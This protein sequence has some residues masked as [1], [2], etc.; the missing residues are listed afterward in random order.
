[1]K[2]S[3]NQMADNNYLVD[4][5]FKMTTLLL[6]VGS[7]YDVHLRQASIDKD[8]EENEWP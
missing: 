2:I 7:S 5:V 8:K 6:Y 4:H 1:M 3:S